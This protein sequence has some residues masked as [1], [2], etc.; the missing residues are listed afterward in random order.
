MKTT[1]KSIFPIIIL[2]LIV[3]SCSKDESGPVNPPTQ[4]LTFQLEDKNGNIFDDNQTLNFSSLNYPDASLDFLVRNISSEIIGMRI[5]VESITG[6]DG[7]MMELCFGQCFAGVDQG[8]S[9]PSNNAEPVV[10]INP[11][12]TQTSSGD[13]FFNTDPGNGSDPVEYTFKFYN[14]SESG[15]QVGGEFRLR[16]RYSQN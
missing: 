9:Y 5:E 13:H 8:V 4:E 6:T 10:F 11:A 1:F 2:S 7:S 16:Y 3:F 12:Q 15:E 14:A